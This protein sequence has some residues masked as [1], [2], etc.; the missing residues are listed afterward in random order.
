MRDSAHRSSLDWAIGTAMP[1]PGT[2]VVMA[3]RIFA[4]NDGMTNRF[5]GRVLTL[6]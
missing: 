3:V 5:T 6:E 2:N 4:D 1:P